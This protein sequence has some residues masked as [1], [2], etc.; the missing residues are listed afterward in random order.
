[1]VDP[2]PFFESP[3]LP[4]S[5]ER[6]LLVSYQFPPGSAAGAL[7]W[8][9]FTP[10]VIQRG[11]TVDVL[12][13][14]PAQL[15]SRDDDRLKELP[16]GVRLYAVHEHLPLAHQLE[17]LSGSVYRRVR[18][19]PEVVP[20]EG[21]APPPTIAGRPSSLAR[22]ELRRGFRTP[23]EAMRAIFAWMDY[24]RQARWADE[25]VRVGRGIEGSPPIAVVSCGPPHFATHEAARRLA[26]RLGRPLVIDLR[27]PWSLVERLPEAIASPTWFR[28]AERH[29]ARAL[30]EAA[31]IVTNTEL[32]REALQQKYPAHASR[33]IAVPN[34]VDEEP[35]P[36][37][38]RGRRFTIAY[39]GAIYL[40]RDPRPLLRAG[41][42]L[43][44]EAA[45]TPEDFG[46]DLMGEVHEYEGMTLTQIVADAGL[47]GYVRLLP[48]AARSAALRMLA[49]AQMLVSL[50]QDSAMA[51]PSKVYEY[52]RFPA[53]VLI[54]AER[55]SA[56][57]RLLAGTGA[58]VVSSR[59]EAG[60]A[61][62]IRRRYQAYRAGEEP[63]PVAETIDLSRKRQ[64]T[65]LLDAIAQAAARD[66]R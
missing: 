8:Q 13:L 60:I 1:M 10:H 59:D 28:M 11:W 37:V 32:A 43:V 45:L 63:R 16:A 6:L 62:V 18:P 41:A 51:I 34:G 33:I 48:P 23:R 36:V 9:R 39:A 12:T 56:T 2:K 66:A 54:L 42:Q 4:S 65:R 14:D 40:D 52:I 3:R 24:R 47:T 44:K 15:D 22:S 27:D 31:L 50:P 57:A 20:A 19:L 35:L 64:A 55:D 61:A 17:S 38:P 58:D 53:W 21:Y 26:R 5:S 29:E 30:R 25:A 46:I 7:R 49:G